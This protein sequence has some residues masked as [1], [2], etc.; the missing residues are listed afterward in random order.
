MN[1]ATTIILVILAFLVVGAVSI[2]LLKSHDAKISL[3]SYPGKEG[4]VLKNLNGNWVAAAD[5]GAIGTNISPNALPT[6]TRATLGGLYAKNCTGNDKVRAIDEYGNI[7]CSNDLAGGGTVITSSGGGSVTSISAGTGITATPN[8]ITSSG[9][10]DIDFSAFTNRI[11]LDAA[12]I[13]GLSGI[14]DTN[15]NATGTCPT[16][17][18]AGQA[19][20]T[21]V[22]CLNLTGGS[23][24]DFCADANSGGTI[25]SI[26]TSDGLVISTITSTGNITVNYTQFSNK[27]LVSWNNISGVNLNVGTVNWSN[28]TNVNLG[29]VNWVN[30]SGQPNTTDQAYV[31]SYGNSTYAQLGASN[32]FTGITQHSN[33]LNASRINSTYEYGVNA[34]FTN[35]NVS[36]S[37]NYTGNRLASFD[38]K[39]KLDY[40]NITNTPTTIHYT[41]VT[42][43]NVGGSVAWFGNSQENPS[44]VQRLGHSFLNFLSNGGF[45]YWN[46]G[47]T[48]APDGWI[49]QGSTVRRNDTYSSGTYS[50][51]LTFN[52]V[53]D[54]I[55][56]S[57]PVFAQT[58][59]TAG[60]YYKVISGTG[61]VYCVLQEDGGSF[62]HYA[63]SFIDLTIDGT[64]KFC[65]VSAT[66]PN[67]GVDAM[68]IKFA[69]ADGTATDTVILVDEVMF[70]EGNNLS[71][72]FT[73]NILDSETNNQ[74][75]LGSK[76]FVGGFI[77][78][79]TSWFTASWIH[80]KGLNI[81][82]IN[83]SN[84][85][86]F[87]GQR[88]ASFDNKV[89]SDWTNV[90]NKPNTTDQTYVT[91]NFANLASQNVFTGLANY[92]R[93]INA[94]TIN[95]T[96]I[97][98]TKI[99]GNLSAPEATRR[100]GTYL[101]T[102]A[103]GKVQNGLL[104]N[105]SISCTTDANTG[106][107]ANTA[108]INNTNAW[109][110]VNRFTNDTHA[111]G[112]NLTSINWTTARGDGSNITNL[113]ATQLLFGTIPYT[114]LP[115]LTN[116]LTLDAGFN[117]TNI[118]GLNNR[119]LSSGEN[120]TA[121]TIGDVRL[122]TN[123]TFTT[124]QNVFTGLWNYF[125]GINATQINST[126]QFGIAANFTQ[127]NVTTMNVSGT[128]SHGKTGVIRTFNNGCTET[129]NSTGIIWEC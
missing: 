19:N 99:S 42:G 53:D 125:R 76:T 83:I 20:K 26:S 98:S 73:N 54:N 46:S 62:T 109:T 68:R 44:G 9:T 63:Q 31:S 50:A 47:T 17:V 118:A 32:Q 107:D 96:D 92:F 90:T 14:T 71:T 80:A 100:G 52:A 78:Q 57:I 41:N 22:S 113:N 91:T 77:D 23:D 75:I 35:L 28:L 70:Q 111:R 102:C 119:L 84:S 127:V 3:S 61:A 21:S 1:T 117:L 121:G 15:C 43:K 101:D 66:K 79:A 65:S 82:D 74:Q 94:T 55:Y 2:P 58:D 122:S 36:G 81:T 108:L 25:T 30:I 24:G 34:N 8:P 126:V 5:L 60:L 129:Q 33:A 105:G 27:T 11:L 64:W 72:A 37:I 128:I 13:S 10:L 51:E 39:I 123:V 110:G 69:Q 87:T 93:A 104:S 29:I 49:L 45:E 95:A 85:I 6:P 112:L 38:N 7:I 89:Q 120:I 106:L 48:S 12:N 86:N 114:V 56:Q 116:F 115:S 18:Y 67:D 4:Q 124:A 97:N 103:A 16:V 59:I 88:L 40:S